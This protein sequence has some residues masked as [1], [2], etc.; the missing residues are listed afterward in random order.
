MPSKNKRAASR[1]AQLRQRRRRGGRARSPARAEAAPAEVRRTSALQRPAG[2]VATAAPI[3]T[4]APAP[5]ALEAR[6][7]PIARRRASRARVQLEP[8]PMYAHLGSELRR[9]GALMGLV[10]VALAVL[11]VVLR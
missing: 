2:A 5:Q 11:T 9:I 1:Q 4:T 8:L 6:E 10:V 3:T 7:S